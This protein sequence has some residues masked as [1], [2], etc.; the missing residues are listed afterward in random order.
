MYI[1]T[2]LQE[3][4]KTIILSIDTI[5]E[6]IVSQNMLSDVIL[7]KPATLSSMLDTFITSSRRNEIYIDT[8]LELVKKNIID[9][10]ILL[11]KLAVK[12]L[13]YIDIIL[14]SLD[15]ELSYNLDSMLEMST[16]SR[17]LIDVL[18]KS[19]VQSATYLFDTKL[20]GTEDKSIGNLIDT[21]L[22]YYA[23]YKS[24]MFDVFMS[25][26]V[27]NDY[28]TDVALK[29]R[30]I[31]S[32]KFA[33]ELFRKIWIDYCKVVCSNLYSTPVTFML[34]GSTTFTEVSPTF[35]DLYYTPIVFDAAD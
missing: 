19:D 13:M 1:D 6:G 23:E 32:S 35:S 18:L 7:S 17:Y 30:S 15:I 34:S 14:S 26:I 16:I 29:K 27:S 2:A 3:P 9:L 8:L 10:D 22:S 28:L 20:F 12:E 21:F 31:I 25:E 4:S 33:I 11:E 24:L 5:M